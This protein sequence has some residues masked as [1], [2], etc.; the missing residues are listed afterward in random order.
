MPPCTLHLFSLQSPTIISTLLSE[1][2]PELPQP[3]ITAARPIRWI[4]Q[5]SYISSAELLRPLGPSSAIPNATDW[6]VLLILHST[7]R[8]PPSLLSNHVRAHFSLTIGIPSSLLKAYAH[9]N[10]RL[11]HPEAGGIPELTGALRKP[12]I[13]QTAQRL[14]LTSELQD[15]A[16]QYMKQRGRGSG[17]VSMLNLLSFHSGPKPR[18]QYAKYGRA[19]AES[20]G[21]SRGGEAKIVGKVVS[22]ET[23]KEERK[24]KVWEEVAL[25]HYPSVLHFAD[26]VASEDYQEVNQRFR[27][28]SLRD[29]CIL[30]TSE[31]DEEILEGVRRGLLSR[32]ARL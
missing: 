21:S 7:A 32:G 17:A 28:G 23:G 31:L 18:S 5:P 14:E 12:R 19:F 10:E 29:T 11:L 26:M 24:G 1:I 8:I 30:M 2:L 9:K 25:A 16:L 6:D 20:I 22:H 3:P 27:V 15:W 4:I 13:A